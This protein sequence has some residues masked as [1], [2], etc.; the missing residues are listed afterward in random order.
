MTVSSYR[1]DSVLKAYHRQDRAKRPAAMQT[2]SETPGQYKD[3]V[4]LSR[5][6][7]TKEVYEKI[8]YSLVD[9]ILNDRAEQ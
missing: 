4:S 8:S 6:A 7:D 5:D 1:I 3:T 2:G 9:I